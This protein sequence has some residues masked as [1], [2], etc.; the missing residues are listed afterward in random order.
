MKRERRRGRLRCGWLIWALLAMPALADPALDSALGRWLDSAVAPPLAE[1]LSRHPRFQGQT[2]RLATQTPDVSDGSSHVLAETLANRLRQR[3]LRVD[4]VRLALAQPAAA[5]RVPQAVDYLVRIE[6]TAVGDRSARV[7]VGVIDLAESLW[8]SGFSYEWQ[9]RLSSAER[10]ALTREVSRAVPG[11]ATSPL[12]LSRPDQLAAVL[13]AELACL[14]PRDL[15]GALYVDSAPGTALTGVTT[16]LHSELMI[17]PVVAITPDRDQANWVMTLEMDPDS[18]APRELIAVLTQVAGGRRQTVASVWVS[19]QPLVAARD[20]PEPPPPAGAPSA[21]DAAT[22]GNEH[23]A[24]APP[25]M[26]AAL[27]TA[28]ELSRPRDAGCDDRQA[29][30]RA[31]VEIAFEL[32]QPAYLFVL[33][34]RHHQLLG[35]PCE[36]APQRADPGPRRYRLRLPPGSF[37][38]EAG[39]GQWVDSRPDGGFYVLAVRDRSLARR[40]AGVLADAPGH[41]ASGGSADLAGWLA[42]LDEIVGA[43]GDAVDWRTLQLAHDREGIV[44]L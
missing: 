26:P 18:D 19:G 31:C 13:G 16:A 17:E 15:D 23:R 29:R 3:L 5:C 25:R 1:A 39:S 4:G 22:P 44:A 24:A 37:A 9:G 32:L 35:V 21:A 33:S 10:K 27:L 41:C 11:S 8:V 38:A 20:T 42:R 28:L 34:T 14:M 6:V 43:G 12:S 30:A 7:Q 2:V 36:S 40:V